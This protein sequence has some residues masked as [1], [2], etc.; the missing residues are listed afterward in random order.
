VLL[1]WVLVSGYTIV[2]LV[3]A[4]VVGRILF[5]TNPRR[6]IGWRLG[7][8]NPE[9]VKPI[10]CEKC[11]GTGAQTL[12]E[13]P[14]TGRMEWG[15][16]PIAHRDLL[17]GEHATTNAPSASVRTCPYCRGIGKCWI[18]ESAGS[19]GRYGPGVTEWRRKR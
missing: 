18:P 14:N 6:G 15:I 19:P 17:S 8:K 3:L 2:G 5:L 4:A 12:T 16:I 9:G 1:T 7:A 10:P 13:N 11:G